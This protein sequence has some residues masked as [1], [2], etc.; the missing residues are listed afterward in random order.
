MTTLTEKLAA[1]PPNLVQEVDDFVDFLLIKHLSSSSADILEE[2]QHRKRDIEQDNNI[3]HF[4]AKE[5][6]A[7]CEEHRLPR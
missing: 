6:E 4:S 5:W 7:Y 2:M 3:V 1:L